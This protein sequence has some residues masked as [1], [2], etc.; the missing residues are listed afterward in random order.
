ME[1]VVKK[2]VV[3]IKYHGKLKGPKYHVLLIPGLGNYL[4]TGKPGEQIFKPETLI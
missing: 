2:S 3:I 4:N 1:K